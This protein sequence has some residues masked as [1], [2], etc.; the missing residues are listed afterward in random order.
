MLTG[1]ISDSFAI[2]VTVEAVYETA[3]GIILLCKCPN[4]LVMWI[5]AC[6]HLIENTA[7]VD[8][9]GV[10]INLTFTDETTK[11]VN[12]TILDD[13]LAERLEVI[14]LN[15]S[16][17]SNVTESEIYVTTA[18]VDISITDD[19]GELLAINLNPNLVLYAI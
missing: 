3:T 4:F 5:D 6:L 18:T 19:D 7:G 1:N 17:Q 2:T 10:P 16:T 15:L 12:I 14:Q 8:Y 11:F 9:V 13:D